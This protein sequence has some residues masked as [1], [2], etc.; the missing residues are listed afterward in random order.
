MSPFSSHMEDVQP[1][2]FSLPALIQTMFNGV[3]PQWAAEFTPNISYPSMFSSIS[4][5]HLKLM[6]V[7]S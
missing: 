1:C 5:V 6:I 7:H 2:A 3:F 4:L